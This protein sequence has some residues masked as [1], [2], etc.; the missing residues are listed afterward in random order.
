MRSYNAYFFVPQDSVLLPR[1]WKRIRRYEAID[2]GLAAFSC[3]TR[4]IF[5][6]QTK[7]LMASLALAVLID[8]RCIVTMAAPVDWFYRDN[9][10]WAA[11]GA[12][13]RLQ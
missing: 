6:S 12:E 2:S 10:R 13:T 7:I 8:T 11:Q 5:I 4:A 3:T 1:Y 9:S